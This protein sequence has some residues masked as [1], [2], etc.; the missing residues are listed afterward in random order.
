MGDAEF[1]GIREAV[2]ELCRRGMEPVSD[3]V[4]DAVARR[5]YCYQLDRDPAL[6]AYA[7][8]RGVTADVEH[9][10]RIPGVP[11]AAFKE[12]ALATGVP[13]RADVVFRTSGTTRGADR[14]GAHYVRDLSLYRA[15][16]L[17]TF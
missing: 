17:P 14:R 5:V 9:W 4:F 3:D 1:A 2:L 11:T 16:L 6:A 8:R 7:A 15:S 12:L 13:D 10:R